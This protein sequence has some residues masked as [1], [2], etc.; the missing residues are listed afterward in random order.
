MTK[1]RVVVAAA[2]A[3]VL[4]LAVAYV[5]GPSSTPPGQEPLVALSSTNFSE[6][7]HAFDADLGAPRLVLLLSPT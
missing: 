4:L 6:F 3:L 1:K 7:E 5:W 2:L